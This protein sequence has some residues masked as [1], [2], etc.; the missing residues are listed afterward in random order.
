VDAK[1]SVNQI[2]YAFIAPTSVAAAGTASITT[3]LR[4][5]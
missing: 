5:Y 1:E 2:F 4:A 3:L